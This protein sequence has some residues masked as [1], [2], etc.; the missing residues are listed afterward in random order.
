[1]AKGHKLSRR[2]VVIIVVVC[3]LLL[4]AVA[5]GGSSDEESH[6]GQ[7]QPPVSSSSAED[8]NYED[9]VLQFEDAGFTNV[10]AENEED[11]V[12]GWIHDEG[13]VEE[14]SINGDTEYATSDWYEPDAKVVV[15]YH[16]FPEHSSSS[17]VA[18]SET[19]AS[20]S[21]GE[22]SSSVA[23]TTTDSATSA[24][25]SDASAASGASEGGGTI[26]VDNNSEFAALLQAVDS[27]GPSVEAFAQKYEGRTVEFDGCIEYLNNHDDYQTRYDYLIGAGDYSPDHSRGPNFQFNNVGIGDMHW[28]GDTPDSVGIG[29]NLHIVARLGEYNPDNGL[30]QL[31]P[32]ETSVR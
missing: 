17:E 11:L 3:V 2:G 1:M 27:D 30:Y 20:A 10:T 29:Q 15:R 5:G 4:L 13:S 6:D 31:D 8:K 26:T 25:S 12:T 18:P 32:V 24:A 23:G 14:V 7:V 19:D 9:V 21:S 22:V 28:T 16:G